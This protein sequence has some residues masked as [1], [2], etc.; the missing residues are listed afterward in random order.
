MSC[1]D[2]LGPV[3]GLGDH[4][5]LGKTLEDLNRWDHNDSHVAAG[6]SLTAD[7]TVGTLNY[8]DDIDLSNTS[9]QVSET[10]AIS[11]GY[12]SVI[13]QATGVVTSNSNTSAPTGSGTLTFHR[14]W[15]VESNPR[16]EWN[17][18]DRKPPRDRGSY[19]EQYEYPSRSVVSIE[20]GAAMRESMRN[21]KKFAT[22]PQAGGARL[23]HD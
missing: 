7:T 11:G 8:Y 1:R 12:S 21:Q 17:H 4:T 2:E 10:V 6:G 9:G 19:L 15:L 23:Q 3:Y 22:C 20:P 5:D 18:A 16:G 14:R 13:H